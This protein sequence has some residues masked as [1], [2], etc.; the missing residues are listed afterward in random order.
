[1]SPV[2]E[3]RD[4]NVSFGRAPVIAGLSFTLDAGESLA[5]IGPTGSGKSVLFRALIGMLAFDGSIRWAPGT[6]IG[7]VPQKLDI[8]RDVPITASDFVLAQ[9]RVRRADDADV[10]QALE[11]VELEPAILREPIGVLSGGQFQRLLLAF[12]LIGQPSVL[13]LDEPTAGIDE[14]AEERLYD[15]LD[16]LRR[17]RSVA[18]LSISHELSFVYRHAGRVLCLGPGGHALG[19]PVDVLTAARL[20]A[21]YGGVMRLH[22]HQ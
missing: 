12:A 21:L 19:L 4:L 9:R 11:L 7:Y 3:V 18:L 14:P 15:R 8:E 17:E 13:L 6:R 22:R 1:M 5:V 20:E 10:R 2:L 16:R